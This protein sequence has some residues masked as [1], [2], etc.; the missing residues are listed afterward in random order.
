MLTV[1]LFRRL[2]PAIRLFRAALDAGQIGDVLN[3]TAEVGDTYTWQL[4][5][6]AGMRDISS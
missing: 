5:T 3:V 2:L 4:T 6:L 1:G